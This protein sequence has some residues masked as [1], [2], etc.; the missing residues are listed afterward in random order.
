MRIIRLLDFNA[1][2]WLILAIRFGSL[3]DAG[4]EAVQEDIVSFAAMKLLNG[5]LNADEELTSHQKLA[6]LSQRIPLEFNSTTYID[7]VSERK[8]VEDYM[9][10]CFTID[11]ASESMVTVSASEPL[12]SEAAY[13]IMARPSNGY[14]NYFGRLFYPQGQPRRILDRKSVV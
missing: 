11:A 9:R 13:M 12:L 2:T 14:E 5:E 7:Q 8:Q 4:D 10:V 3:Y 1:P 6:C